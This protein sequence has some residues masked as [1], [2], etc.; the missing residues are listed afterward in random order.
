MT[1]MGFS[2]GNKSTGLVARVGMV[3]TSTFRNMK[4]SGMLLPICPSKLGIHVRYDTKRSGVHVWW[5]NNRGFSGTDHQ[6]WMKVEAFLQ[7]GSCSMT[8]ASIEYDVP[9]SRYSA[10]L[11]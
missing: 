5:N 1:S 3:R 4:I 11:R 7:S 6:R 10:T 9:N 2:E 8:A